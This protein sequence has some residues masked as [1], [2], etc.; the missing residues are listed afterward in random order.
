MALP[1][2]KRISPKSNRPSSKDSSVPWKPVSVPLWRGQQQRGSRPVDGVV[3]RAPLIDAVE[4]G[5]ETIVV[6][7]RQRVVLVVMAARA[8][9]GQ[10]QD[11]RAE[12][13]DA[14][15]DV[16]IAE[17]FGDTAALVG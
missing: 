16:L 17:L 15:G 6:L 11:R 3:I 8:F 14:V 10:S 2:Q 12:R 13:M 9:E 7:H 4:E 5:A 1:G